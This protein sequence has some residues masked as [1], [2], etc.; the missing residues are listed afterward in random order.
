MPDGQIEQTSKRLAEVEA[1][2]QTLAAVQNELSAYRDLLSRKLASLQEGAEEAAPVA[3]L[4]DWE[5]EPPAVP[6]PP[7]R[8]ATPLRG[9]PVPPATAKPVKGPVRTPAPEPPR[10]PAPSLPEPAKRASA[11]LPEPPRRPATASEPPRKPAGQDTISTKAPLTRANPPPT[12]P[13]NNPYLEPV[14]LD[15]DPPTDRP[16]PPEPSKRASAPLP[17]SPKRP[18]AMPE[19]P[20]KSATKDTINTKAPLPRAEP[21]PVPANQHLEPVEF[22]EEPPAERRSA[23]RRAGNPLSV[24]IT[25][26]KVKGETLEGWIVDRSS[27]G[28]RL[29]VDQAMEPGALL[30]VRPTKAHPSLG[31]VEV[32][33]R[34]CS[35]ERNSF[36]VGCQFVNKLTWAELQ[37]FG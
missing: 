6:A 33:V 7:P 15:E 17:E 27:G 10:K 29:L 28:I 34:S 12:H 18:A 11:P 37:M 35:P 25:N 21:Q 1:L 14:E 9:I 30:N 20:K 8:A 26:A 5:P 31:W 22:D 16:A 32:K 24:Q 36:K 4:A 19:P 2:Q 13:A 23:P 3:E